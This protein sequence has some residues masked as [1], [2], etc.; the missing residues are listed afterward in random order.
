MSEFESLVEQEI[1]RLRRYA[2]ALSRKDNT[3]IEQH[4]TMGDSSAHNSQMSLCIEVAKKAANGRGIDVPRSIV[5]QV[6][7]KRIEKRPPLTCEILASL[8]RDNSLPTPAEQA[9]NL[10]LYLG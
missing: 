7:C 5:S 4:L 1:P 9:N 10:M 2:R 3:G 6:L 8:L